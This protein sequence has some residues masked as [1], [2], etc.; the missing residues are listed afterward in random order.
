MA[1]ETGARDDDDFA[2]FDFTHEFR[3]HDV[4]SARLG[5][6]H[7]GVAQAANDERADADRIARCDHHVV[8]QCHERPGAFDLARRLDKALD[9]A[10]LLRAGEKVEDDLGIRGGR[11]D[12]A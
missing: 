7:V 2:V 12:R 9:H 10:A 8:G 1:F 6:E 3:T 4:E 5:G 11:E